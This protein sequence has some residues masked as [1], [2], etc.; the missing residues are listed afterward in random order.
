MNKHSLSVRSLAAAFSAKRS[1]PALLA[2]GLLMGSFAQRAQAQTPATPATPTPT[3]AEETTHNLQDRITLIKATAA[4]TVTFTLA[5][6]DPTKVT[7]EHWPIVFI[8]YENDG[9]NI[10]QM[11][12]LTEDR[13]FTVNVSATQG[14]VI[15]ITGEEGMWKLVSASQQIKD[16][17][18][19]KVPSIRYIDLHDNVLGTANAQ[20]S[21]IFPNELTNVET[22]N[23][24]TN[25]L[26]NIGFTHTDATIRE[27]N[28]SENLLASF[29]ST[30]FFK[31]QKADLSKNLLTD[32]GYSANDRRFGDDKSFKEATWTVYKGGDA[33]AF[34][35]ALG[36]NNANIYASRAKATDAE[37]NLTVNKL[38]ILTLPTKPENVTDEHYYFTLQE[39]YVVPQSPRGDDT[40]RPL[41]T[42]TLSSQSYARGLASS[43]KT[44]KYELWREINPGTDEYIRV[45]DN[46]FSVDQHGDL[47]FRRAYGPG[48]RLFVA[49][50]NEGFNTGGGRPLESFERGTGTIT[51]DG[52]D[53]VLKQPE[54]GRAH[55]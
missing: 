43:F 8:D 18:L 37:L 55:V 12:N 10:R 1:L 4:G 44:T 16:V 26:Q 31:L 40:W 6:E 52:F 15:K 13:T 3:L 45:P 33:T 34:N 32:I 14:G 19:T 29:P 53:Q 51:T 35:Q 46:E 48:T 11:Y 39:R 23:L 25:K 41:E 38:N 9:Q 50:T 36:G 47:T 22:L 24:A 20:G 27:L 49:M 7:R 42:M 28:V 30:H 17:E 2:A 21:F 5:P 54:I